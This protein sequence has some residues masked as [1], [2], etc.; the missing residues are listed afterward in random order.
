MAIIIIFLSVLYGFA[1]GANDAANSFAD[2]IGA[3]VGKPRTGMLICGIMAFLGALLEGGKVSKTIGSGIIP[4]QYLTFEI[5]CIG[6]LAAIFWVIFATY[7]GLPVSTTHSAVG[8][9][10]GIGIALSIPHWVGY[11]GEF[12]PIKWEVFKKI[13]ICWLVT[14]TASCVG[15]FIFYFSLINILRKSHHEKKFYKWS[16]ILLTISSSYVAY[17]WGTNDVANAVALV[18]GAKV[19]PIKMAC[20]IGGGA[21]AF[22]AILW[23]YKV[24]ENVGFNITRLTPI[25]G[26]CADLSCA[27][28]IHFFTQLKVP[29]STTHALVGAIAGVG[30][31]RGTNVV[32]LKIIRDIVLAWVATPFLTGVFAILVFYISKLII[33]F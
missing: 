16:K 1:I 23:G 12:I 10:A 31:A 22:G 24:A 21:M 6:I 9:V 27:F 13:V 20:V 11:T 17:T 8:A 14:P 4:S 26:F 30:L 32:N 19:L 29:V 2:W 3:R 28:V 33:L 25:M 15:S 18:S 5:A 7:F